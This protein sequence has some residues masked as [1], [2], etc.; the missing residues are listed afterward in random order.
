MSLLDDSVI[1]ANLG[2]SSRSPGH[3][4]RRT[5]S[6]LRDPRALVGSILFAS[7][8]G[9]SILAPL[10]ASYSRTEI[11]TEAAFEAPSHTH[12][13]GTDNFGRDVFSRV[14]YGGRPALY[15][16]LLTVG[17]CCLV[18]IPLGL[19]AGFRRGWP[20]ALIMR[21]ADI[22]LSMPPLVLAIGVVAALGIGP[23]NV[24]IALSIIYIPMLARVAR[25]AAIAVSHNS[26]VTAA[27]CGGERGWQI[28]IRQ[29]LPNALPPVL[30]QA[31]LL[32]SY[33]LLTEASLSFL[34]LG[35]QADNPSWGR[36]LT[37]AIPLIEIAPWIG[38]FPG[39]FIV[40]AVA[41]LNLLGDAVS[42]RVSRRST[43]MDER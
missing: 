41:G 30:V 29:V 40:A 5:L 35:T 28:L 20:D 26:Y 17:V 22:G 4:V 3:R 43:I 1:A 31:V 33:A 8:A 2:A 21:V 19:I 9:T 27:R 42:D 11:H 37:D 34:G 12:W 10:L 6:M 16:A 23:R 7:V 39:L 25:A 14:I 13:F 18:G 32:F 36:L 38:I 15:L 24:V